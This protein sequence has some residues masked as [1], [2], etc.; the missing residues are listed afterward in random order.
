MGIE[1]GRTWW[2]LVLRG[3]IAIVFGL[4]ALLRP[5]IALEV[6]VLL[7][8]AYALVD[9]IVAIV[10]AVRV[11]D[12]LD[13]WW[14]WLLEGLAGL[15]IGL[16]TFWRPGVTE[17]VLLYIIAAWA[18]IT[19]VLE[20]VVAVGLR[21]II[22][23][24]WLLALDGILSVVLGVLLVIR[25]AAGALALTWLIALYALMVGVLLLVLGLRVRQLR[26]ALEKT[27]LGT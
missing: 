17:T 19:G 16:F 24:D 3:L 10:V 25:R 13:G 18:I 5:S 8:G 14:L 11:R 27:I 15:A 21:K 26:K 2:M 12:V 1:F 23:R 6:L 4:A 7:F 22:E 20:L 9:G